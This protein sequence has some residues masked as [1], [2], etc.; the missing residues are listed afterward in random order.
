MI[1]LRPSVLLLA[2]LVLGLGVLLVGPQAGWSETEPADP[3]QTDLVKA[4]IWVRQGEY[5]RALELYS[6]LLGEHPQDADLRAGYIEALLE[7]DRHDQA[8][9]EI[10]TLLAAHPKEPR[11]RHLLA[12]W[13]MEEGEWN[14][15]LKVLKE[16][17]SEYPDRADFRADLGWAAQGGGHWLSAIKAFRESLA[18]RPDQPQLRRDLAALLEAHLPRLTYKLS[19]LDQ[20]GQTKTWRQEATFRTPLFEELD[21]EISWLDNRLSRTQSEEIVAASG[22]NAAFLI[23]LDYHPGGGWSLGLTAGPGTAGPREFRLGLWADYQ[24]AD[25]WLRAAASL[26]QPWDDPIE[27][28]EDEGVLDQYSLAGEWTGLAG[29]AFQASAERLNYY[30]AE[31]SA[32]A[33]RYLFSGL[34]GRIVSSEPYLM[35]YYRFYHSQTISQGEAPATLLL[36][37]EVSHSLGAYLEHRLLPRLS[38]RISAAARYDTARD[39]TG[40]GASVGFRLKACPRLIVE[41]AY[42]YSSERQNVA[43]GQSHLGMLQIELLF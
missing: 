10:E 24:R 35:V 29:W 22:H 18:L 11:S 40:W 37:R 20:D 8:R 13:Y 6:R 16:L 15:A 7:A 31:R 27:A 36:D 1:G 32:Y 25:G 14:E 19:C 26:N 34:L 28:A 30:L 39:L 12:R 2:W 9:Q 38:S 33:H 43:G 23:G 4:R 42:V 5:D 17:S 21:L 41:P 3:A